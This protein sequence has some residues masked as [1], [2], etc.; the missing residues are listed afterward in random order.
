MIIH[1][2]RHGEAEAKSSSKR[3]EDRQITNSGAARVRHV[4]GLAREWGTI[5][6]EVYTSP[7]VRA[8]ESAQIA[9]DVFGLK[10]YKVMGSLEPSMTPYEV[11]GAL[12]KLD[13]EKKI[14]LVSHQPLVSALLSDLLG[15]G[16]DIAMPAG[17]LARVD[18]E[19]LPRNGNGTL[20]LFLSSSEQIR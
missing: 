20:V 7:L 17:S 14:L 5:V 16:I 12:S 11:Y 15:L 19:G 3:D 10:N 13:V 18:T 9:C 2:L 6:D 1:I 4:L 8:K